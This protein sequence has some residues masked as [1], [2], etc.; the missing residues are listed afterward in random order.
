MIL[1]VLGVV[2]P[3][4]LIAGLGYAWAKRNLPFDNHTISTLVMFIGSPC[5][6]YS[7]LVSNAPELDDLARMVGAALLSIIGA[8]VMGYLILKAL[9]W[10]ITSFLPSLIQPNGGNMGLPICLLAFGET[11]LALGMAYFFMN[12]ISQYTLGL[13]IS[14]GSFQIKSLI[15]QPVIWAV[16]ITLLVLVF[17]INMPAWFNA[18]A[19]LLGGLTIPAMLLMLGTSLAGLQITSLGQTL[20]VSALRLGMGVLLGLGAIWVFDLSGPVAGVVLLQCA[21]PVAV[22]NY[23]FAERYNR[24]PEKVAGVILASTLMSIVTLP[25]L[26]AWAWQL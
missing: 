26:V 25:L 23:V 4:F 3:V 9:G 12:S 14:S 5:L 15:E 21:M 19:D 24:E 20:T 22:F 11:G 16:L 8:A 18:T 7:S 1:D 13:A 10:K 17:E 2:T 6:I